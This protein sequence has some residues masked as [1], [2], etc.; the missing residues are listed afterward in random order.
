VKS[1]A[2]GYYQIPG[3]DFDDT[4]AS[5]VKLVSFRVACA[6]AVHLGLYFDHLDVETAFLNG[7]LDVELYM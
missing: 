6:I 3:I 4:F 1:I 7:P 2:K 5:V